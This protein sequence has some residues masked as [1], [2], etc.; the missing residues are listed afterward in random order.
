M[1]FNE[2]CETLHLRLSGEFSRFA[3]EQLRAVLTLL[4]GLGV[5]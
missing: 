4:A 5:V 1:R 3:D 2:L